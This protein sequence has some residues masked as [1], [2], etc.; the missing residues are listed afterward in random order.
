MAMVLVPIGIKIN[1]LKEPITNIIIPK[2]IGI[3]CK[4]VLN[5]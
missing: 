5:F 3:T 4:K 1:K 2:D